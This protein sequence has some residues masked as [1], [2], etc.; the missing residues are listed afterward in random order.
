MAGWSAV[1][2]QVC[3]SIPGSLYILSDGI[4]AQTKNPHVEGDIPPGAPS[5]TSWVCLP[6][7]PNT[8]AG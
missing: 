7:F 2:G 6:F 3:Q 8:H 1:G 5:S 4:G